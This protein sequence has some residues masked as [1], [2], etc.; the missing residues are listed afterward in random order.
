MPPVL[1]TTFEIVYLG[2][3][4]LFRKRLETEPDTS[5]AE[6][7][8]LARREC[9]EFPRQ[10]WQYKHV[11]IYGK[12]IE[13]ESRLIAEGDRIEILR[14]LVMDPADARRLRSR[15]SSDRSA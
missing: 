13:D 1:K 10:A 14:P 8:A 15:A 7:M 4:G 5:L 3:E 6:A 2:P 12:L 11:A 9:S